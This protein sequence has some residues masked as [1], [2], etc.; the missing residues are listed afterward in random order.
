M[1]L[2]T[3]A[4]L[5]CCLC[6]SAVPLSYEESSV[7]DLIDEPPA[8]AGSDAGVRQLLDIIHTAIDTD[9]ADC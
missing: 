7:E 8:G 4:L 3:A 1:K 9:P 2:P 6:V 5:V